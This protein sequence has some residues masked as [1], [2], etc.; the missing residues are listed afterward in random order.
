MFR[1]PP[2]FEPVSVG[3]S[4]ASSSASLT[5]TMKSAYGKS[6]VSSMDA[7]SASQKFKAPPRFTR[8]ATEPPVTGPRPSLTPRRKLVKCNFRYEAEAEDELS[9]DPG[10]IVAVLEEIDPGWWIGELVDSGSPPK[11]G[12][13][14]ALYCAVVSEPSAPI[15]TAKPSALGRSLSR[16]FSSENSFNH[17]SSSRDSVSEDSEPVSPTGFSYAASNG[18]SAQPTTIPKPTIVSA[19]A[20]QSSMKKPAVGS[21]P[22][23]S[24]QTSNIISTATA[25]SGSMISKMKKPPPPPPKR[26]VSAR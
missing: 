8:S 1:V 24:N 10:D 11:T 20:F 13:F 19:P 2:K 6:S 5:S 25:F 22:P 3:I 15:I 23:P 18:T 7:E 17:D 16:S 26:N 4:N 9:L 14:P 21:L 12:L